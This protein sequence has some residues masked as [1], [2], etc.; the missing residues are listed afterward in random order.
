MGT[1]TTNTSLFRLIALRAALG[2]EVLGMKH[3]KQSVYAQVKKEFGYK[4][5]KQSVFDQL[6]EYVNQEKE[7]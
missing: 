1:L 3:S 6:D 4:G 5:S 2:M 7:K